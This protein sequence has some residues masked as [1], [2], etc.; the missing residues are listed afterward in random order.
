MTRNS[1]NGLHHVLVH[2]ILSENYLRKKTCNYLQIL[3]YCVWILQLLPKIWQ[4]NLVKAH[5]NLLP[6]SFIELMGLLSVHPI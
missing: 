4:K 6:H 2:A 5:T 1:D 3:K